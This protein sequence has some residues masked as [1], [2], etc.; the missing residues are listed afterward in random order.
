MLSGFSYELTFKKNL[1]GPTRPG[2]ISVVAPMVLVIGNKQF[3][4]VKAFAN[5][6]DS[7]YLNVTTQDLPIY[8]LPRIKV[9]NSIYEIVP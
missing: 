3:D 6:V 7:A 8:R 4:N 2:D 1:I 5:N 9:N